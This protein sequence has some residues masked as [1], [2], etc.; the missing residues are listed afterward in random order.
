[1]TELL[2]AITLFLIAHVVPPAPPV[3][4]RL[5]AWFGRRAYIVGYSLVSL[6]FIVWIISVTRRAPYLPLWNPAPW[7]TLIPILVM[8]VATWLLFAGLIEANPLSISLRPTDSDATLGPAA[9]V[10]RHPLLWAF[11]LWAGSHIPPNGDVISLVLFGG[12]ALLAIIG[13]AVVDGRARRRLGEEHWQKLATRTSILPFAAILTGRMHIR[14]SARLLFSLAAGVAA[15]LWFLF[16]GHEL[17]IG[18]NQLRLDLFSLLT[19][20]STRSSHARSASRLQRSSANEYFSVSARNAPTFTPGV[21][22]ISNA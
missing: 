20:H 19:P 6:T 16:Q 17:L 8:P 3:R 13:F 18:P 7:Q 2:V 10:T 21:A 9:A 12:M 4:T 15:Y 11:L 14:L 22:A 5:I 1:M